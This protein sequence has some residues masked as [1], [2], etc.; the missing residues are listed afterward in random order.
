MAAK[1]FSVSDIVF[2]SIRAGIMAGGICLLL[3]V[4][5]AGLIRTG[6]VEEV[7]SP[8]HIACSALASGMISGRIMKIGKKGKAAAAL[9][10]TA[11][12]TLFLVILSAGIQG[13]GQLPI[14]GILPFSG[15]FIA[16]FV[17]SCIMQN[18]KKDRQREK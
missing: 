18:N 16:G 15:A 14:T 6:I 1:K 11:V 5:A 10:S 8:I 9:L 12:V 2:T 7:N 17:L 3:L 13:T 4:P